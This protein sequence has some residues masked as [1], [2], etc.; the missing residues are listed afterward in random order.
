MGGTSH[1][2]SRPPSTRMATFTPLLRP[3]KVGP[4]G[5]APLYL[6]VRHGGLMRMVALGPR[7]R[8]RDWNTDRHEARKGE[9]E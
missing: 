3:D 7:V 1:G 6:A 5:R 4:D 8:P 2:R 9:P